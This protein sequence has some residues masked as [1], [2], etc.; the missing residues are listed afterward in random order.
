MTIDQWIAIATSKLAPESAEQVRREIGEHY[1]CALAAG[2]WDIASLGDPRKANREYRKVLLTAAE[3]RFVERPQRIVPPGSWRWWGMA[4]LGLLTDLAWASRWPSSGP[5]LVWR[6]WPLGALL[7][8]QYLGPL[9]RI[10]T[11]ARLRI[12]HWVR[13]A[14]FAVAM[15]LLITVWDGSIFGLMTQFLVVV[16][17]LGAPATLRRKFP[18]DKWPS[19]W[20]C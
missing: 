13:V 7:L 5:Y 4:V 11:P 1:H 19:E 14:G 6:A 9:L 18:V 16:S 8:L 17:F 15:L 20:F 3:A 10:R 2:A 12:W